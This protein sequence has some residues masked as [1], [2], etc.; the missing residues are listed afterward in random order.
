MKKAFLLIIVFF[1][2]VSGLSAVELYHNKLFSFTH[3]LCGNS[4]IF[5]RGCSLNPF[6]W[7]ERSG[8]ELNRNPGFTELIALVK[9]SAES[10]KSLHRFECAFYKAGIEAADVDSLAE[11]LSDTTSEDKGI[12][13]DLLGKFYFDFVRYFYPNEELI[14]AELDAL[15][16]SQSFRHFSKLLDQQKAVFSFADKDLN[17]KIALVP[18]Y[19]SSEE[20]NRFKNSGKFSIF[21]L[22]LDEIQLIEV[23]LIQGAPE[24]TGRATVHLNAV[25]LHEINHFLYHGSDFY[26]LSN[27]F[28]AT[29]DYENARLASSYF[30]ET[31]ATACGQGMAQQVYKTE[32]PQWYDHRIINRLAHEFFPTARQYLE[33]RKPF[34]NNFLQKYLNAFG[35]AY[36]NAR[37]VPEIAFTRFSLSFKGFESS[38]L[39]ASK[40]KNTLKK[41]L[42]MYR[43]IEVGKEDNETLSIEVFLRNYARRAPKPWIVK[44]NNILFRVLVSKEGN[45]IYYRKFS[46]NRPARITF[47]LDSEKEFTKAINSLFELSEFKSL[48]KF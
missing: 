28:F 34:D 46:K 26:R 11:F 12:C 19:A 13:A 3:F 22:S 15:G 7:K 23:P 30:N 38:D 20:F 24:I 27:D 21:G 17:L 47:I 18:V 5:P 48:M 42:P 9:K 39:L 6:I 2:S 35:E 41:F 29:S 4:G 25:A 1:F 10:F 8:Q 43:T 16:K 37:T 33:Q 31:L 44:N 36:P 45:F 32:D 14:E 40:F